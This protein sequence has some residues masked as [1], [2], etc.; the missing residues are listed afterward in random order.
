MFSKSPPSQNELASKYFDTFSKHTS[1]QK[2]QHFEAK[3]SLLN[4][5]NDSNVLLNYGS[6]DLLQI[7]EDLS[8]SLP[9]HREEQETWKLIRE[10]TFA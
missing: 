7:A 6:T 10:L 5:A 1:T 8:E 9:F 2:S 3:K 4:N